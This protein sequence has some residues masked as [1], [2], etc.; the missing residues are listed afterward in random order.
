MGNNLF[1]HI[2]VHEDMPRAKVAVSFAHTV[3]TILCTFIHPRGRCNVLYKCL[4][5][6]PASIRMNTEK[7]KGYCVSLLFHSPASASQHHST[8]T[9]NSVTTNV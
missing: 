8:T 7:A 1:Q 6:L 4:F 2:H 5:S 9:I 3:N